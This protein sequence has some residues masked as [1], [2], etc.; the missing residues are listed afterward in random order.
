MS[1][2]PEPLFS[3]GFVTLCLA[4]SGFGYAY[5]SFFLLPKYMVVALG[6]GPAQIG[7]VTAVHGAAVVALL[8]FAG[9]A[10]DRWGRR[11]FLVAGAV[12]MALSSFAFVSVHAVGP[13][14]YAI[15]V[16]QA[17]GFALA[18][19]AGGALSVDLAPPA[20]MAQALGVFGLTFLSMNAIAPVCIEAIASWVGWSAAFAS[21][22]L[23]AVACAGLALVV[24]DRSPRSADD[25]LVGRLVAVGRRPA[26]RRAL[27]VVGLVG[28]ALCTVFTF[29]QP[30]ALALGMERTQTFFVAYAL[31]A[32]V[33]RGILGR[34][35]DRWGPRAAC[36]PALG[37]YVLVLL[38]AS[39][40][41]AVGLGAIG[42]GLGLAHG[43]FYPAWTAVALEGA[44]GGERGTMIALLQSAFHVGFGVGAL[45][46][47]VLAESAGY[48]AVMLAGAGSVAVALGLVLRPAPVRRRAAA[49]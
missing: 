18:F 15:R 4:Q 45:G 21:A 24:E 3:R 11:G 13:L 37:L 14:L 39:D 32:M 33:L 2:P 47:G 20:R 9:V 34:L 49:T 43:A 25:A 41:G 35:L 5:S 16:V 29:H 48:P 19:A 38:A 28:L 46:L 30:F 8:P 26:T 12:L 36:V 23:G 31:T 22:G 1:H 10:V 42:V 6:A 40:L 27:V 17:L 44:A 7:A